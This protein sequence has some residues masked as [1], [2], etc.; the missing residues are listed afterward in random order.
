MASK[1]IKLIIGLGNPGA[2]Y[3]ETRHNIGFQVL[4]TLAYR[5]Q[6]NFHKE[7]KFEAEFASDDIE[8]SYKLNKKIK[9]PFKESIEK[10]VQEEVE[11]ENGKVNVIEKTITEIKTSYK[12]E[13][14]VI[15]KVSKFKLILAK[16]QTY[17]NESGR[18]AVKLM[19]F[20]KIKPE[21][22]LVIHDDVSLDTGKLKM[23]FDSGAGGQH[24][25]EDIIEKL[26][27]NKKFH[28]LK[29]GVG[30]D[31]GGDSRANYVLSTFPK[32]QK[33][34][35]EETIN[36]AQNLIQTWLIEEDYQ[37]ITL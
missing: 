15:E 3:D 27:G 11:D 4:E 14:Q 21:D 7:K 17:M 9:V 32:S 30:P 35:L 6:M 28:R 12:K 18:C 2:K 10:I 16:P 26:G 5:F 29:F 23:A 8:I 13:N 1:K 24:G 37:Q 31:P 33:K 19:Q 20:Y 34:L 36:Q 25:V 22:M